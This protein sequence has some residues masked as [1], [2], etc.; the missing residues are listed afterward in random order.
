MI[1]ILYKKG[2]SNYSNNGVGHLKD[3][4]SCKVT[5]ER[6]GDYLLTLQYPISGAWYSDIVEGAVVKAKANETSE[7][8]LFRIYKSSKPMKGVV[9]FYGEHI[10]YDLKGLPL[11]ALSMRGTT[12]GAALTAGFSASVL[13]H[14]FTAWSDI[15]TLNN[16]DITKPRSLRNFCGGEAGSVLSVWGGEFEFDNFVVKLH[17]HRGA[18]NGVVINYGKNLTDAKQERNISDCYTHFCPYAIKKTETRNA[19]GEVTETSEETITLSDG[20]IELV[21][22]ENIGHKKAYTLDISDKFADGEEMNEANLRAHAEEYI[23][24]H[25][26]GVP[27]VNITLSFMQIWD[28]PE[29]SKIAVFERVALC[30]TV[31]VRFSDLGIDAEAKVIKTE[32]DSLEERFSKIEVGDAKSTLADTVTSIEESITD[33]KKSLTESENAASVALQNAIIEATNKI[34]GNSGGYVVLSPANNPQEI[35]IMNTPDKETATRVWRWNSSGLGYSKNG[36]NGEYGLA[37]TM[38]GAIV[39]DFITAGTLN[40]INIT[41]CTITGGSLNINDRFTV[42]AEGN[43]RTEGEIIATSGI[44]GGCEIKDGKLVITSANITGTLTIGQLPD[45]VAETSDIPTKVSELSN[46]SGYQ[47]KTGVVS[48][49]DGRITADYVEAL[50]ISVG[51]AQIT[52]KLTAGQIDASELKVSAANITGTL[53]IGQLPD[54]VA[55]TSDIPTKVSELSNDSGYQNKTGVVSIID[56]RITADYVEALEISVGAANITG[57]LTA[58]QINADGISASNVTIS[59]AITATSGSMENM[60]ITGKLTF[61]GNSSYYINANYNDGSYYINLP[62]F[63]VDDASGAVFSGK[64]SAASGSFSGSVTATSGIFSNCT[65]DSSCTMNGA[66]Q[67]GDIFT[68]NEDGTVNINS[69]AGNGNGILKIDNYWIE[70]ESGDYSF[71]VT[72]TRLKLSSNAYVGSLGRNV[73][74]HAQ[75]SGQ[76]QIQL[77]RDGTY[78]SIYING[79]AKAVCAHD[80]YITGNWTGSSSGSISSDRNKKNSITEI[81]EAYGVLFDNLI[82]CLFKYNDGTSDRLHSGFIAQEV[83]G[84]MD[85]AGI[86]T[87]DFAAL[88]IADAGK[89]TEEWSLRYEEFVALNTYEIQKLKKRLSELESLIKAQ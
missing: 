21:N 60:T 47:N 77:Y 41:G 71:D 86:P 42:D 59:G 72:A 7:L 80:L 84:A 28:S 14:G 44:I 43:V 38:D 37:M 1:P 49:I 82:P 16:I 13:S 9:T 32:Y 58:S 69:S 22:P 5:E 62:G 23:A 2:A 3:A 6:H 57:K 15:T 25:K 65:I 10:S 89:D 11:C 70:L 73:A 88:C 55:E 46:D 79:S 61:G 78:F 34:T 18:N 81:G 53:T 83:K 4:I 31:T 75:L 8:Q 12:P 45:S 68:A 24:S 20:V 40:A 48:I 63:R 29:Y 33:A 51:A 66:I 54:S 87:S 85:A 36:Y 30:D 19:A 50:E 76:G 39:A 56:G 26:L 74:S 35:L 64:L 52:G 27:K 67:I 17:K